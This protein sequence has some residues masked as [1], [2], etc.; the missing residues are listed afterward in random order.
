MAKGHELTIDANLTA[1]DCEVA[2]DRPREFRPTGADEPLH[3]DD[4]E[5]TG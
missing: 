2:E 5:R 1:T 4:L 3:A